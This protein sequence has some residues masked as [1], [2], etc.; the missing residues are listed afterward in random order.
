MGRFVL[1]TFLYILCKRAGLFRSGFASCVTDIF[2]ESASDNYGHL[3]RTGIDVMI[4]KNFRN[5]FAKMAF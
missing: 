2:R 3:S 4:L 1:E 5:F